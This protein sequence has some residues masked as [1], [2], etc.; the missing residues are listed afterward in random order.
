MTG[1]EKSAFVIGKGIPR[2]FKKRS[3]AL[4]YFPNKN[5]WMTNE[6]WTTILSDFDQKMKEMNRKVALFVDNA[7]CHSLDK[8]KTLSHIKV[9]FLPPN[10]TSIIQPLDQGI[11]RSFKA[12]YRK[13][14]VAQQCIWLEQNLTKEEFNK[15]LNVFESIQ[16]IKSSWS[17]VNE[18]TIHNCFQKAGFIKNSLEDQFSKEETPTDLLFHDENFQRYVDIDLNAKCYEDLTDKKIVEKACSAFEMENEEEKKITDNENLE[19][20]SRENA[21]NSL[22]VLNSYFK[23]NNLDKHHIYEIS[24]L[25]CDTRSIHMEKK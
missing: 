7:P 17:V 13:K 15:S 11:I 23:E 25:L 10:T 18:L 9:Y 22:S 8:N 14:I 21:L 16:L 19:K 5:A 6:I 2:C 3:T 24:T 20:I 4:P 12:D 1:S